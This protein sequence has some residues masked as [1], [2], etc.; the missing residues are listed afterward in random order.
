CQFVSG[1]A[2]DILHVPP[3][4]GRVFTAAEDRIPWGHPYA[5]ISYDYWLRRFHGDPGVLGRHVQIGRHNLTIV[6]VAR[7][8]FF[9][10][11]PGRFVDIWIPAMMYSKAALDNLTWG[12]FRILGRLSAGTSISQLQ[13]RLDPVFQSYEQEL[14]RR[15]PMT[16]API[17]KQYRERPLL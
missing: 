3:A 17:Q 12:W 5:V 15:F 14:I 7:E 16:P 2:F 8:G 4:L 1:D 6:G 9:G 11:E 13:A 10:V